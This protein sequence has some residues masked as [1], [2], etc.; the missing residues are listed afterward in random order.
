MRSILKLPKVNNRGNLTWMPPYL[1][2]FSNLE[3][4]IA[5]LKES[6]YD[7]TLFPEGDGI[8]FL[9]KNQPPDEILLDFCI[10]FPWMEI[11]RY[12]E[13]ASDN[14]ES[15][16]FNYQLIVLPLSRLLIEN[17]ILDKD[18][19]LFPPGEFAVEQLNVINLNR[20][21]PQNVFKGNDLRDKITSI[22]QVDMSVYEY[23]PLIVFRD[24][25][26]YEK[27]MEMSHMDD[28]SLIKRY[29]E[30][31][32]RLI[33]I[34]RFYECDYTLPDLLPARPGIWNDR[35][36]T[37]LIF[38]TNN[39][40]SYV[41]AREVENR[42]CIKGVGVAVTLVNIPALSML[43]PTPS[44]GLVNIAWHALRMNTQILEAGTESLKFIQ[45]MMLFEYLTN[46]F[47]F[48]AFKKKKGHLIAIL[49][50]ERKVYHEL[51][52]E[53]RYYSEGLRT[54]LIHNGKRLEDLLPD[55][56]D[57]KKL[58]RKLQSYLRVIIEDLFWN[59]ELSWEAYDA[60]REQKKETIIGL[61]TKTI[62]D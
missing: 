38:F 35:Y 36:S 6:G 3:Q 41:Q 2:P 7:I 45:V 47:E 21:L 57:I 25:I 58:F 26:S 24:N 11:I 16:T 9:P 4:G 49:T 39:K 18:I 54:E 55:E 44:G 1:Y 50:N 22:T 12:P 51:S 8:T 17:S 15:E 52:E 61:A 23:S 28:V 13:N 40:V 34:I 56:H 20:T 27:Y 30:R 53:F 46:P 59:I 48:A 14:F 37:V 32:D 10:A 42:T 62:D 43:L 33:D 19:C 29:A 31:A 60:T 5:E